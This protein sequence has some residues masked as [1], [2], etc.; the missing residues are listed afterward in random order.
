MKL[1]ISNIQARHFLLRKQLLFEPFSLKGKEGIETVFNALRVVQYDPLNPCGR[2]ADLVLQSRVSGYHPEGYFEW[3]YGEKKGIECYDKELC[4][5]PIEDFVLTSHNRKRAE[6]YPAIK[7][8]I[9]SHLRELERVIETIQRSGPISPA[10]IEDQKRIEDM[11]WYGKWAGRISLEILWKTGRTVIVKRVGG[12]K[13]YDLAARAYKGEYFGRARAVAKEHVLRRVG[14]VGLIA[15]SGS[16]TAWQGLAPAKEMKRLITSM[17]T[18]GDLIEV[19]V[20][21]VPQKYVMRSDDQELLKNNTV[22]NEKHMC[23]IAPLD[24][25]MWDR[26]MIKHIFNFDYKWEVYVPLAKRKYGYY[27]LPILYG[28]QLVG[29]IEPVLS[30]VKVLTIKGFWMEEQVTWD[31]EMWTALKKALDQFMKYTD[32]TE[33]I[34]ENSPMP[35]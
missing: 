23:F 24:T 18:E 32:A 12:K 8:Y 13:Y 19:S 14:S 28:D 15:M 33:L 34:W 35:R 31:R 4:I 7:K 2:N 21:E 1:Q 26:T 5:I 16:G 9:K 29:R 22:P 27:V 11:N 30:K 25:F 20:E 10:E 3:L 6:S 17:I